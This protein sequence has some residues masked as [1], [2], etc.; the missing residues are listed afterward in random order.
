MPW[1]DP[2]KNAEAVRRWRV[3]HPGYWRKY[4]AGKPLTQPPVSLYQALEED[5][6]QQR[7]LYRLSRRKADDP[8]EYRRRERAWIAATTIWTLDGSGN[9]GRR[10]EQH[11]EASA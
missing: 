8:V 6:A 7:E 10:T 9:T 4:A 3:A 2:D 11:D 1:A 5:L